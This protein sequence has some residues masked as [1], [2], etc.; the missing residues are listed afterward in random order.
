M[1]KVVVN[2]EGQYSIWPAKPNIPGGWMEVGRSGN[3]KQCLAYINDVWTE[4]RPLG[5]G[6]HDDPSTRFNI[7]KEN[8]IQHLFE[9]RARQ[10]PEAVALIFEGQQMSYGE[11]NR[12][13][14]QV[15]HHLCLMGV[16]PEIRVG[17]STE[18]SFEMVI[19]LLGILKAGGVYVPM[20]HTYPQKRLQKMLERAQIQ[21]LITQDHL[22]TQFSTYSGDRLLID[23]DWPFICE[24]PAENN[25]NGPSL[26]NLSHII[27]TSGS[28]GEPKGAMVTHKSLCDN[29]QAFQTR[30]GVTSDDVYLHTASIAFTSSL[31]QLLVPL[32]VGATLV[33][34]TAEQRVNPLALF[35]VIKRSK[36]TILDTVAS[37]WDILVHTL[38]ELDAESRNTV[39]DNKL[40]MILSSGDKLP[41]R[42]PTFWRRKFQ[43]GARLIN[44]YGQTET[45]GNILVYPIPEHEDYQNEIVPLGPPLKS[46]TVHLLDDQ[47]QPVAEGVDAELCIGGPTIAWGYVNQP[48]LTA[49]KF[50]P[51]PFSDKP[52]ARLYRTGD[53]GRQLS[54]TTI[55]FC[56]RI[57]FQ[58]NMRGFRI[59]PGEIEMVIKRNAGVSE[60]VVIAD[61]DS[62]YN[63]RLVVCLVANSKED[64]LIEKLRKQLG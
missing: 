28:T 17:L 63:K 43:H 25:A 29:L 58:I 39:L 53:L 16:R 55:A 9:E 11:L 20:D 19:G 51:D 18:R 24:H 37:L 54:K 34:T 33:I 40:R 61:D 15:A 49:E 4:M 23:K 57:D 26:T 38:A 44:M 14:N 64:I 12:R 27:F 45:V 22:L 3:K 50:V 47:M 36:V 10:Y 62:A 21:V 42:T 60:A 56:G 2:Q 13:A 1:F 31:R 46:A 7:T 52:G 6:N 32:S 48:G 5:C 35:E 30:L 8:C 59:E 41:S